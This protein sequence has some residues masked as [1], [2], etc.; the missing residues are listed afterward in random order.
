MHRVRGF[1][2][3]GHIHTYVCTRSFGRPQLARSGLVTQLITAP[4][5][6]A[7]AAP[8]AAVASRHCIALDELQV[9]I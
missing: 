9:Q 2:F 1:H 6:G 8:N 7:G 4:G 5:S 3:S